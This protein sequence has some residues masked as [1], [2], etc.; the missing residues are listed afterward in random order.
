MN[1]ERHKI[2]I[3][4]ES[5]EDVDK[6]CLVGCAALGRRVPPHPASD[7][8]RRRRDARISPPGRRKES[9]GLEKS[10]GASAPWRVR[11]ASIGEKLWAV[12]REATHFNGW[13][14]S[15]IPIYVQ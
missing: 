7:G 12:K 4:G 2:N 5:I 9:H 8:V 10:P 3:A 13:R 14:T 6:G 1:A 11:N 15:R